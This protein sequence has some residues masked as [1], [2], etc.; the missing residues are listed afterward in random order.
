MIVD[1]LPREVHMSGLLSPLSC[2]VILVS[3]PANP[4]QSVHTGMRVP[5]FEKHPLFVDTGQKYLHQM[6]SL[7]LRSNKHP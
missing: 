1:Q 4:D 6:K 7:I 3:G 2:K 5:K